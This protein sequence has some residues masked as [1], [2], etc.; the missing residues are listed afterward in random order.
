M[1]VVDLMLQMMYQVWFFFLV[2]NF[3]GG[4]DIFLIFLLWSV[5]YLKEILKLIEMQKDG[6]VY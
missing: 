5:S 6:Y 3:G 2:I 4:W 1:I